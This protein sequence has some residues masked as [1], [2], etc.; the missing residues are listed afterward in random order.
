MRHN[1]IND[2]NGLISIY[3]Y[4]ITL[5]TTSASTVGGMQRCLNLSAVSRGS[6][7]ARQGNSAKGMQWGRGS[8][9]L[10]G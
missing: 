5:Y 2:T 6:E 3:F 4:N 1:N 10:E 7:A 9:G 8:L